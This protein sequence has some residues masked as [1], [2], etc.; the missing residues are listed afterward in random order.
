MNNRT[1]KDLGYYTVIDEVKGLCLSE[2]GRRA[3][4]ML[5]FITDRTQLSD[6]QD[7]VGDFMSLSSLRVDKPISFPTIADVMEE[8][9]IPGRTLDGEQLYRLGE[10]L[11][12]AT[13]FISYCRLPR[14]LPGEPGAHDQL[15][16]VPPAMSLFEPMDT[17]LI[18]LAMKLSETLES[19]GV[20]KLSH[21]AIAR[22]TK[23]V[24]RKRAER[25]VFSQDFLQHQ[26]GPSS[27]VQPVFRDGRVVLPI[28]NDQRSQHEG[29]IHSSSASGVTV[30][31][32]P[33]RLVEL[34]NQV[35]MAQQQIQM[36][37]ARILAELSGQAR[38]TIE[39]LETLQQEVAYADALYARAR[40]AEI[41]DCTRPQY[42]QDGQV[43]IIQGRHP[44]LKDKAVP[45][46]LELDPSIKAVVIS[47]PNAGGKTVTIK[48]VGLFCMMHQSLYM[49]PAKE[50]TTLPIFHSIYTDIG[51]DQSIEESLSTFS[52]HMKNI[53]TILQQC[54]HGSLVILD[55]LG[56]GTDP[57]EG[58]AL[59][60][61]ILEYCVDHAGL[62]L[63]TSHHSVLKQYA[64]AQPELLNA[65]MEFDGKTHEP[66]FRVI[67]GLPG[68]SHALDTAR[69]MRLPDSVLQRAQS[70]LG[71]E[72]VE[73]STI[74]RGLE[75]KRREAELRERTL[76]DRARQLQE[77]VR[78]NDLKKLTLKQREQLLRQEQIGDL[79]RFINEKRSELENLVA[80]LREGEI[81]KEKTRKVKAFISSMEKKQQESKLKANEIENSLEQELYREKDA[82]SVVFS[83]G[84][85]VLAGPHKREGRIVRQEKRGK[86]LVAIGPMKF[87]MDERDLRP[88]PSR[89]KKERKKVSVSYESRSV[90]P[91]PTIDVRGMTLDQAVEALSIQIEGALV[92]SMQSFSVIHGMG[93]GILARGLHD[94]LRSVSQVSNYY[95]ARPEDGGYGKTYIELY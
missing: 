93:D 31:M 63:V 26:S 10:Y 77:Q 44:L 33:Y 75:E 65:S 52:G 28:R 91:R 1:A 7:I 15:S 64:Y 54:D 56:S 94:Y 95:F 34:N 29:I 45:I 82:H 24:E 16:V 17:Q 19:P 76:D 3:F 62:T 83:V 40:Y 38:D 78:Q 66:T 20:V 32:E 50:G 21:P 80:E 55:E 27:N 2:S 23:E 74:I 57:I 47:G 79:S 12:A 90:A 49:V 43:I 87:P 14:K 5:E 60:R 70:F 11:D 88:V 42:G 4:D 48:T 36:E 85:D 69:S 6:R 89:F 72:M 22:L 35:V 67:S 61:A 68:E 51:D 39:L 41:H 9:Q 59:A 13:K 46:S 53:G 25:Q 58:S 30:F 81:T 84:M 86:W 8:L 18:K 73:I 37:I 71:S 92:H